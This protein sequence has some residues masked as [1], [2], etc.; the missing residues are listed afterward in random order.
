[1]AACMTRRFSS[2]CLILLSILISGCATEFAPPPVAPVDPATA[3]NDY[4][5]DKP[6]AASVFAG[7]Y[8]KLWD[9]CIAT[10]HAELFELDRR[11][12]RDG[13]LT[14]HPLISRQIFEFWR[15]DSG[16]LYSVVQNSL[17]T[18]RRTIY[19]QFDRLP[20]GYTVTP[21]VVVE[22]FATRDKRITSPGQYRS[23]FQ[24]V[25]PNQPRP[26]PQP[27]IDPNDKEW[28]A[29]GRDL[30]MEAEL[31]RSIKHALGTD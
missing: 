7:D 1:M 21:K 16:D 3:K 22:R 5:L 27:G 4:W 14:T 10:A 20:G 19:F 18:T 8:D 6:A 28:Y 30:A 15:P 26:P 12:Y 2:Q 13:L 11:D 23:A 31:A 24:S 17:Q 29:I 25:D 9:I